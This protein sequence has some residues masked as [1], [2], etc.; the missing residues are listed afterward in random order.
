MNNGKEHIKRCTI[1][2]LFMA[3]NKQQQN[4]TGTHTHSSNYSGSGYFPIFI[5]LIQFSH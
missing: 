2:Q 4:I 5:S 3:P 1:V